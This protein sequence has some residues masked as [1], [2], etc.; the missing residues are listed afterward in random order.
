VCLRAHNQDHAG[1][2]SSSKDGC[3]RRRSDP[4]RRSTPL[5]LSVKRTIR[6][7]TSS[8]GRCR[9]SGAARRSIPQRRSTETFPARPR[10]PEAGSGRARCG[11]PARRPLNARARTVPRPKPT[12]SERSLPG[13][14]ASLPENPGPTR[15]GSSVWRRTRW[16]S[17]FQATG[18]HAR[19]RSR[20]GEGLWGA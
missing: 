10:K 3:N 7:T 12:P 9:R 8:R 4:K 20:P 18:R 1:P 19:P 17:R 5:R 14:G 11:R 2:F 16:L 13:T 15:G 6:P